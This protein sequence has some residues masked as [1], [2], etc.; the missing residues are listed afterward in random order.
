MK[1]DCLSILQWHFQQSG[2][3]MWSI[4][5]DKSGLYLAASF[6]SHALH[7]DNSVFHWDI[8]PSHAYQPNPADPSRYYQ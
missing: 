6:N 1:T 4:K 5:D 3:G 2:D 8:W 7:A